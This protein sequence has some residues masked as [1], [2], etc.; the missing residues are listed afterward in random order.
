MNKYLKLVLLVVVAA[1]IVGAYYYPKAAIRAGQSVVGATFSTQRVA[2]IASAPATGSA[3]TTSVQNTDTQDRMI[4]SV[5]VACGGIGTSKTAYTGAGLAALQLSFATSSTAAPA[6]NS[7]T[8]NV[9]NTLTIATGTPDFV[10]SSSTPSIA[11]NVFA[12]DRWKAGS[13]LTATWNATNTA[14]CT[15]GVSYDPT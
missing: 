11:G 13:Y 10:L 5:E 1:A 3:T 7:N 15:I 4:R 2:L 12:F 8:N 14:A 9:G 6:T